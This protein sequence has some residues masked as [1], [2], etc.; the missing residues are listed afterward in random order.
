MRTRQQRSTEEPP[1]S[2]R[3]RRLT[4]GEGLAFISSASCGGLRFRID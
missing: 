4:G 1:A 2:Q 3:A